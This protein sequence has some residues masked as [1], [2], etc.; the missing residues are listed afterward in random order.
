MKRIVIAAMMMATPAL[1]AKPSM[2]CR[3]KDN[4]EMYSII[5]VDQGK[6]LFQMGAGEYLEG[7]GTMLDKNLIAMTVNAENGKAY[8]VVDGRTSDGLIKLEYNDGR[9]NQHP[10]HCI[11]K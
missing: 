7:E 4:G 3:A 9:I 8:M 2:L 11:F 5:A 6:V 1:A 10:I